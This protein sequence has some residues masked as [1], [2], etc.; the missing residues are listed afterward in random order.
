MKAALNL[1]QLKSVDRVRGQGFSVGSVSK[2]DAP[3]VS[4]KNADI[5]D[6]TLNS[7]SVDELA[8]MK[9]ATRKMYD[10]II[11]ELRKRDKNEH[12]GDGDLH[13][14]VADAAGPTA[15][16]MNTHLESRCRSSD[17]PIPFY[18]DDGQLSEGAG[19]QDIVDT[20]GAQPQQH[21]D[22]TAHH[23]DDS[24]VTQI[25]TNIVE[26]AVTS[27]AGKNATSATDT[28]A[29]IAANVEERIDH[30][31]AAQAAVDS[32]LTPVSEANKDGDELTSAVTNIKP[33]LSG[34]ETPKTEPNVPDQV[35]SPAE[36]M[37]LD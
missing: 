12:L 24:S 1:L 9:E 4:L 23:D 8:A 10:R 5:T 26:A 31:P 14:N 29:N 34:I 16:E 27:V 7:A 18:T 30:E 36:A 6:Q 37:E 20:N 13:S 32:A 2:D 25:V 11:Y 22:H 15:P 28:I 3:G 33:S 19:N 21:N 17:R 35:T